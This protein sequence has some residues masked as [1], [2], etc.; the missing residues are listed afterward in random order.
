MKSAN[1]DINVIV[2]ANITKFTT[3]DNI[4]TPLR[5][6]E[7]FFDDALVDMIFG[8]TKLH[9]HRGKAGIS[10]TLLMKKFAYF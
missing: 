7:L 2:W 8:Y 9:S 1:R 4:V 10:L 3:L 5:L 6:L